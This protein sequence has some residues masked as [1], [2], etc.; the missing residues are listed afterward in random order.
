MKAEH[1]E[2]DDSTEEES[3]GE[4]KEA[5]FYIVLRKKYILSMRFFVKFWMLIMGEA[6]LSNF[7]I[8]LL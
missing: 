7:K 3:E 5:F 4:E 2:M 1:V 8:A 6:I